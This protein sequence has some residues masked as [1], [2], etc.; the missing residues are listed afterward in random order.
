M[1]NAA[2]PAGGLHVLRELDGRRDMR[3]QPVPERAVRGA[4]DII[5][6]MMCEQKIRIFT[7][8]HPIRICALHRFQSEHA[9]CARERMHVECHRSLCTYMT[10]YTRTRVR[11]ISCTC[12]APIHAM[13]RGAVSV[14]YIHDGLRTYM[15]RICAKK[16]LQSEQCVV[17]PIS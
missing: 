9:R 17:R 11:P 5:D 12:Y 7:H 2:V 8:L 15:I 6:V 3:S 13:K 16:Q 1:R 4:C 14:V 10:D